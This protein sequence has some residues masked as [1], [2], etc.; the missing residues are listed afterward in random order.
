MRGL[1][2]HRRSRRARWLGEATGVPGASPAP[3]AIRNLW[4]TTPRPVPT[5]SSRRYRRHPPQ[6]PNRQPRHRHG[7]KPSPFLSTL[8]LFR[9]PRPFPPPCRIS[10]Y[11]G[12]CTGSRPVRNMLPPLGC[13]PARNRRLRL[14]YSLSPKRLG[15]RPGHNRLGHRPGHNR[16]GHR[17]GPNRLGYRLGHNLRLRLRSLPS[18]PR[19]PSLRLLRRPPHRSRAACADRCATSSGVGA[20]GRCRRATSTGSGAVRLGALFGQLP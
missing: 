1:P 14:D 5:R 8:L 2:Q 3:P 9:R 17:P 15:H 10:R 16:L 4:P 6:R 13:R 19:R 20:L 11:P 7:R 18:L 12:L